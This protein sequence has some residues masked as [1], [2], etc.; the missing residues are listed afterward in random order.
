MSNEASPG[1]QL[2]LEGLSMYESSLA[3]ASGDSKYDNLPREEA[4]R[5]LEAQMAKETELQK[6]SIKFFEQALNAGLDPK[7]EI[8]CRQALGIALFKINEGVIDFVTNSGLENFPE[9]NRGVIE[10]EKSLALDAQRGTKVFAERNPQSTTLQRLDVV[11]QR[12]SLYLKNQFGPEKKLPYLQGKLTLLD[13]L[14]VRLPGLCLSLAFYYKDVRNRPLTLEW[15]KNAAAA[16][17]YEDL[18]NKSFFYEVAHDNKARAKKGVDEMSSPKKTSPVP[19]KKDSS[20][21]CFIATAVYQSPIAPEVL[22]FRRYRD[23]VLCR[24]VPGRVGIN[25]YYRLSPP[26]ASFISRSPFLRGMTNTVLLR[27]ILLVIRR[28]LMRER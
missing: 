10:L 28:V 26:L 6:E 4:E 25:L 24:S 11:W 23:E 3:M 21:G 16:D 13:Y 15:L 12:Q 5:R 27:P 1:D 17:D 20:G 19:V 22:I 14:G 9:L 18:D 2:Y 7:G 8:R